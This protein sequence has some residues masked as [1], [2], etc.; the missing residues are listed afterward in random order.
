MQK[1]R[2]VAMACI[3]GLITSANTQLF[4]A[5]IF[6]FLFSLVTDY[7]KPYLSKADELLNRLGYHLLSILAFCMNL[8]FTWDDTSHGDLSHTHSLLIWTR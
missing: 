5:A 4:I 7:T 6:L 1:L 8:K 3:F 2:D